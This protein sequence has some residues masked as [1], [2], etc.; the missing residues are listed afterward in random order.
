MVNEI[1]W[2]ASKC[3]TFVLMLSALFNIGILAVHADQQ[4]EEIWPTVHRIRSGAKAS[5]KKA[6][7]VMGTTDRP[8]NMS[9]YH[10]FFSAWTKLVLL[11]DVGEIRSNSGLASFSRKFRMRNESFGW[12]LGRQMFFFLFAWLSWNARDWRWNVER[13]NSKLITSTAAI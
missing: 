5:K 10:N 12:D 7:F 3:S 6:N 11:S 9:Y 13:R 1:Y 8:A 2:A 4:Q